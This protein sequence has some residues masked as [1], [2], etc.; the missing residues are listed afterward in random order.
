[1]FIWRTTPDGLVTDR[2]TYLQLFTSRSEVGKGFTAQLYLHDGHSSEGEK[3]SL[4]GEVSCDR[5]GCESNEGELIQTKVDDLVIGLLQPELDKLSVEKKARLAEEARVRVEDKLA[6][7][8]SRAE[9]AR[10]N[11]PITKARE[12]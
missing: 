7:V 6:E 1:M 11:S 8:A 10:K 3:T 2:Y 9:E 5:K 4:V 12:F